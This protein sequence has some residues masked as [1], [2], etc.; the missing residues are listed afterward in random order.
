MFK[1]KRRQQRIDTMRCYKTVF[2]SDDGLVVLFDLMKTSHL[3]KPTNGDP[4]N[5]GKRELAL[6]IM[7]MIEADEKKFIELLQSSKTE[8][9]SYVDEY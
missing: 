3:L 9:L 7:T 2:A 8:D 5:E 1:N 4:L 6:Y